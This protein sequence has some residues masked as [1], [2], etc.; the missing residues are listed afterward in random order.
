[1]YVCVCV[2][3]CA[4]MYVRLYVCIHGLWVYVHT[5]GKA[6]VWLCLH[7][8]LKGYANIVDPLCSVLQTKWTSVPCVRVCVCVHM[9]AYVCMDSNF[10][11]SSIH[12]PRKYRTPSL[13]LSLNSGEKANIRYHPL[14][15]VCVCVYCI[16]NICACMYVYVYVIFPWMIT[17]L[18]V[19]A[20]MHIWK[21][22]PLVCA[23]V[24][25]LYM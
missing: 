23:C 4:C 20:C 13:S 8:H 12:G 10:L 5:C 22:H 19:H 21:Y 15:H 18:C 3:M 16:C 1:M 9:Y 6:D 2:C 7:L 14:V 25:V 24:C 17:H 11:H